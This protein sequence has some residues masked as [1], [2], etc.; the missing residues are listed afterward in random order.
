MIYNPTAPSH[1]EKADTLGNLR[2][3]LMIRLGYAAQADNPPSSMTA[4]LDEFINEA[5]RF[6]VNEYGV[7]R[8]PCFFTWPLVAGQRFYAFDTQT[9]PTGQT[10]DPDTVS[11]AGISAGDT[12]WRELVNRIQPEQYASNVSGPPSYYAVRD[13]IEVWPPPADSAWTLRVR[14]KPIPFDMA[15]P[16][17]Y[18]TIDA[19][20]V[21][22]M[23]LANAKAHYNK[24]DAGNAMTM[25]REYVGNVVAAS[26]GTRRYFPG[27]QQ[28]P[29]AVP[30]KLLP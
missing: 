15:A 21:F 10:L 13:A 27:S 6:L 22:L 30:P 26:H 8:R 5:Q 24:P 19:E 25:M 3:R 14:A 7:L 2:R 17:E 29:V 18:T 9:D 1:H 16:G 4:L 12:V 11:W 23:A 20:P 28:F